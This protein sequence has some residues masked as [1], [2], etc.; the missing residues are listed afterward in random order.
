MARGVLSVNSTLCVWVGEIF[1]L[2]QLILHLCLGRGQT[3][4]I[5]LSLL[6]GIG[7]RGEVEICVLGKGD[8]VVALMNTTYVYVC[9]GVTKCLHSLI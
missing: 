3:L 8:R 5:A 9:E 7:N 2:H 6:V 4:T 1:S